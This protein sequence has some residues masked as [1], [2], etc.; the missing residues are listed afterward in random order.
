MLIPLT[1]ATEGARKVAVGQFPYREVAI[2]IVFGAVLLLL[3]VLFVQKAERYLR[4]TGTTG[5][6]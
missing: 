6:Y 5:E 4:L 3:G 2:L 1:Y